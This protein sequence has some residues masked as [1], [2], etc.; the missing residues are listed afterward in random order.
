MKRVRGIANISRFIL[1]PPA[2][3]KLDTSLPAQKCHRLLRDAVAGARVASELAAGTDGNTG[4]GPGPGPGT[5]SSSTGAGTSNLGTGASTSSLDTGAATSSLG[6]GAGTGAGEAALEG[7]GKGDVAPIN[8][9]SRING[10]V[11]GDNFV[12]FL[13]HKFQLQNLLSPQLQG[14]IQA[15]DRGA[16]IKLVAVNNPSVASLVSASMSTLVGSLIGLVIT[17][18]A[19]PNTTPKVYAFLW[20]AIAPLVV[21]TIVFIW[22]R[23]TFKTQTKQVLKELERICSPHADQNSVTRAEQTSDATQF[24]PSTHDTSR[25]QALTAGT[26]IVVFVGIACFTNLSLE[27]CWMNGN[28]EKVE[29]INR[30]AVQLIE[31]TIGSQ[32]I[33]AADCRFQLA[34]ALRAQYPGQFKE[35]ESLLEQN[36]IAADTYL[37][38]EPERLAQNNLSLGRVLDQTGRHADARNHYAQ[39]IQNWE[40]LPKTK[41]RDIMVART[42]NRLAMLSL[43]ERDFSDASK[44]QERALKLDTELGDSGRRSVGEDLNDLALIFDQQEDYPQAEKLYKQAVEVKQKSLDPAD[45]SLATSLYNLAEIERLTGDEENS[46][47]YLSQAYKIWEQLLDFRPAKDVKTP[48]PMSCYMRIMKATRADYERPNLDARFDGLRPYLGRQ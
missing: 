48:D 32:N 22:C 7:V 41:S 45:Y 33:I 27:R 8:R 44:F 18:F 42:L 10:R 37:K 9:R 43:K 6:T 28:Y 1:P 2:H 30:P 25:Q 29:S 20:T 31:K 39:A 21:V 11:I 35:A 46:Q 4:T 13:R 17:N 16:Q 38:N 47:K 5:S 12:L 3:Y 19:V 26:A 24:V 15:T 34:E 40:A 36:T 14:V 23:L